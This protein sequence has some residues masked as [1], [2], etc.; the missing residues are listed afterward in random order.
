MISRKE[1]KTL[2]RDQLKGQWTMAVLIT[3]VFIVV[4]IILA[5]IT[6]S[7]E[8]SFLFSLTS[9][10]ITFLLI[11]WKKNLYLK[12]TRTGKIK[13]TDMFVSVNTIIKGIGIYLLQILI[14][15]PIVIVSILIGTVLLFGLAGGIGITNDFIIPN[16]LEHLIT[17]INLMYLFKFLF[18]FLLIAIIIMI[19]VLVL[20]S[21][22]YPSLILI[23]E[24]NSRGVG[25]CIGDSFKLIHNNLISFITLQ[26]SYLGWILL[27]ILTLGLGFLWIIPY[28][29]TVNMNF[30]NEI[31][32]YELDK[33]N[34]E[35]IIF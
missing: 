7:F 26:L 29:S 35:N 24:D 12:L 30:F 32:G 3:L 4:N 14:T 31:S 8:S 15:I 28:I 19:P 16:S 21:Y 5:R 25:E 2:S 10:I 17:N 33:N 34:N 9:S 1:L 20:E 18:I 22:M 11:L 27:G 6:S 13:F 23:C